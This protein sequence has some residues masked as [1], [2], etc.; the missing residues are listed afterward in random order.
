MLQLFPPRLG[1]VPE[2]HAPHPSHR[3]PC[4]GGSSCPAE[5]GPGIGTWGGETPGRRHC[6]TELK[7]QFPVPR[8]NWKQVLSVS[9]GDLAPARGCRKEAELR[10]GSSH[11]H[12][13]GGRAPLTSP[14]AQQAPLVETEAGPGA[15]GR[16]QGSPQ[17]NGDQGCVGTRTCFIWSRAVGGLLGAFT[18]TT[19]AAWPGW[20]SP[21]SGCPER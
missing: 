21:G 4:G 8:W 3:A 5:G 12:Q 1:K 13:R 17:S 10:G 6:D 14:P 18:D 11:G 7:A 16:D 15:G 19:N 20:V 9:S 2:G